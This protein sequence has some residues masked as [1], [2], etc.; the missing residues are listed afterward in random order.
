MQVIHFDTREELLA[1]LKNIVKQ[2]DNV[3]VK[4]SHGMGFDEVVKELQIWYQ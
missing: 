3:L 2:G 1:N 4:A